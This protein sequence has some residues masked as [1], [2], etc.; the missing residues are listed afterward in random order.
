[1]K[2]LAINLHPLIYGAFSGLS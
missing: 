1:M 2:N